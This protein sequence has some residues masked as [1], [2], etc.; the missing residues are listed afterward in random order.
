MHNNYDEDDSLNLDT[1]LIQIQG[2][3]TSRWYQLG[4]ALEVDNDVLEKCSNYPPEE[5][6]IEILDQWLRKF[7]GRPTWR[8]VASALRKINLQQLANDIEM[9][10]ETGMMPY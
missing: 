10:Y 4:E 8:G 1:L 2:A 6:I 7:P 5:S 3:V 9:V